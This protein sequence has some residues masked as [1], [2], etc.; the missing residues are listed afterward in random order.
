MS[1]KEMR[2]AF[3]GAKLVDFTASP[4]AGF[5]HMDK[6]GPEFIE[7]VR[8]KSNGSKAVV[9]IDH[10][11]AARYTGPVLVRDHINL[12]GNNPLVGPNHPAGERFPIV[13]G[14]YF[15]DI[16][17]DCQQGVLAGLKEGV[18]PDSEEQ[19]LLRTIGADVCS[20]NLV[21]S[22]LV[23]AHAG[24]KV[25]GIVLGENSRL[26]EKQLAEIKELTGAGK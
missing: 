6:F 3:K 25:L 17:K 1:N 5:E 15:S 9:V 26:S 20:Y 22:M 11:F 13:Q 19:Q 21:P 4:H 23:A 10:G 16:L 7:M 14:I 18:K 8:N 2:E 12:S 24:W